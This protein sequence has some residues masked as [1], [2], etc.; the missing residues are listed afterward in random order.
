[1]VADISP[2]PAER[3]TTFSPNPTKPFV[4][5]LPTGSS[6]LQVYKL[7]IAAYRAGRISF[8]NVITFNMDEYVSLP[9]SHSESYYS[10]MHRH[11]FSHIDIQPQNINLLDGNAT[12]LSVE[13]RRYEAKIK[14]VGGIELFL[15]GVGSD[16][17]IAFNEPGSSL[18]S[19]TRVKSLATETIMANA[20]FFNGDLNAVPRMALTV[21]VQTI[22]DAREVVIIATGA[23]KAMAVKQAVEGGV[24]HLCT[25]S[26]LQMHERGMIV[27]DEDATAECRVKTV[28]VS[29]YGPC[30]SF[31]ATRKTEQLLTCSNSISVAWKRQSGISSLPSLPRRIYLL[32][33]S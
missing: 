31:G 32:T 10:F 6:P 25:L 5:G 12:D 16:G 4:I 15:G 3:I 13:C 22:M 26:C 18:V 1:M 28:N 21:G 33:I 27:V 19:R 9:R 24:S 7:L 23:A 2:L 14:E 8:Q 20:R 30:C 29:C 11:F 17:H